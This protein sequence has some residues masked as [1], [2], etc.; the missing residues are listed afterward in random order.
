MVRGRGRT[1]NPYLW[2]FS[3]VEMYGKYVT[4]FDERDDPS[5]WVDKSVYFDLKQLT[6]TVDQHKQLVSFDYGGMPRTQKK[7]PSVYGSAWVAPSATLTGRVEVRSFHFCVLKV[8]LVMNLPSGMVL[9]LRETRLLC[10]SAA[11]PTFRMIL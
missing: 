4:F 8:R 7:S 2:A 3:K 11:G 5:K 1:A 9:S 6:R 10:A